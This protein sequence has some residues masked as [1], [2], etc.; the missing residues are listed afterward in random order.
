MF[1][2]QKVYFKMSN[3]Q[4]HRPKA[5]LELPLSLCFKNELLFS[6]GILFAEW[7][8]LNF[9]FFSSCGW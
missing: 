2:I 7:L 1:K 5:I 8:K 4:I 6:K 9:F 3:S